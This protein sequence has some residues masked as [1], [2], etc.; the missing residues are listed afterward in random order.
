MIQL[1]PPDVR[2]RQSGRCDRT[3]CGSMVSSTEHQ[4]YKVT[5]FEQ[6]IWSKYP[7]LLFSGVWYRQSHLPQQL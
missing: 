2:V 3:D 5:P 6:L 1:G 4:R 7:F